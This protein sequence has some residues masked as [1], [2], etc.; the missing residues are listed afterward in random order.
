MKFVLL[1]TTLS[2]TA[3]SGDRKPLP[4]QA[5]ND[6]VELA[7]SIYVDRDEIQQVLGADIGQ[8]YVVAKVTVTPKTDQPLPI[9]PDDFT[10]ISGKDGQRSVALEP[11]Q[12]AGKGGLVVKRAG[13]QPGGAGTVTNGPI[14]GGVGP[15]AGGGNRRSGDAG[16]EAT[17][18]ET[19][20]DEKDNP[21]LGVLKAKVLPDKES[22]DPVEGLLYF[23][24]DG[25]IKPKDLRIIYT[26]KAGKL[27]IDFENPKNPKK[28]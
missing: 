4:G 23:P 12:I 20:K 17:K 11:G 10:I 2:L 15:I 26:G 8:G 13:N 27:I 6:N 1:L 3:S 18:V 5:G 28:K 21:L 9:S 22:T 19:G 14:W 24:I 25:K 16:V 7:A